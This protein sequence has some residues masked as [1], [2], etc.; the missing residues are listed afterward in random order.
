MKYVKI[1]L[2]LMFTI[3]VGAATWVSISVGAIKSMN[4]ESTPTEETEPSSVELVY[5]D[6]SE[7][8]SSIEDVVVSRVSYSIEEDGV[9]YN[10][11]FET[12]TNY[13]DII[14]GIG[15]CVTEEF[16][17]CDI[18]YPELVDGTYQYDVYVNGN[19]YTI[20]LVE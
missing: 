6:D 18:F 14:K 4:S 10:F 2:M 13:E 8:E 15:E 9:A 20:F 3:L 16:D 19:S 17:S 12:P 1:A 7:E 5:V 11:M